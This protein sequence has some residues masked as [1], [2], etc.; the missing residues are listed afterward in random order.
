MRIDKQQAI[1]LLEREMRMLQT[2]MDRCA[3]QAGKLSAFA[4]GGMEGTGA[5]AL[6]DGI[7]MQRAVVTAHMQFYQSLLLADRRNVALVQALPTTSPGVLDTVVAQER[8][9]Q[10][11]MQ[12]QDLVQRRDEEL[13]RRQSQPQ[14]IAGWAQGAIGPRP[15]SDMPYDH[16]IACQDELIERNERI[17]E[18][19]WL[20][21][22]DATRLYGDI[23]VSCL[24]AA[25]RSVQSLVVTGGW[26]DV[27]WVERVSFRRRAQAWGDLVQAGPA[28]SSLEQFVRG[29]LV[30]KG[31]TWLVGFDERF[32]LLGMAGSLDVL[33]Y[34]ASITPYGKEKSGGGD[35]AQT[36]M[37]GAEATMGAHVA[38][39]TLTMDLDIVQAKHES[40]VGV[41]S[42][43]LALGASR[44]GKT[45]S[46]PSFV[47]KAE[48]RGTALSSQTSGRVGEADFN[49]HAKAKGE[50]FT[51]EAQ[52]TLSLGEEG[53]EAKV[54][55]EAY[56]VTGEISGGITFLGVSFD[57]S[58]LAKV[59]GA[60]G[61]AG[62]KASPSAA[63]GELGIGLGLGLGT[64]V[65]VDWSGALGAIERTAHKLGSWWGLLT[66]QEGG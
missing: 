9:D 55:A 37:V 39:G 6:E 63:E 56:V 11:R 26:G 23:D 42:V 54:G 15:M 50:A 17:L 47:A 29:E 40:Y 44:S 36:A 10:A 16:L 58:L 48:A 45:A 43:G 27:G 49:Y 52:T 14:V 28:R 24:Q 59:G 1:E 51:A 25:M 8:L 18:Q 35:A 32:W 19:A 62:L 3:S 31:A 13:W 5:K 64:K 30:S 4:T 65:K 2:Q 60:G 34:E 22:R 41:G 46:V 61:T 38:Y 53:C 57:T 12:R 21:E 33:G 66:G 20:Y 7:R